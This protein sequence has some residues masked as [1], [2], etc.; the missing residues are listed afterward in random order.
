MAAPGP[1]ARLIRAVHERRTSRK[2]AYAHYGVRPTSVADQK[3][4]SAYNSHAAVLG[5]SA[6]EQV[7]VGGG[8][9][10]LQ[11]AGR[12]QQHHLSL[13]AAEA[14]NRAICSDAASC[15]QGG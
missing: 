6:A 5:G 8:G 11:V 2:Q 9:A 14:G 1:L 4:I 12:A 3:L 7:C 10:V 15:M 13:R